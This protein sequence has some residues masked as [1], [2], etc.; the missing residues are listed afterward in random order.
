MF[1]DIVSINNARS[2]RNALGRRILDKGSGR[3]RT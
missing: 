3:M 2:P 1:S